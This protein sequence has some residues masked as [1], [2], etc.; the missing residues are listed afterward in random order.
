MCREVSGPTEKVS[1]LPTWWSFLKLLHRS[2]P[3]HRK[4]IARRE[5]LKNVYIFINTKMNFIYI[6]LITLEKNLLPRG[7]GIGGGADEINF[8]IYVCVYMCNCCAAPKGM[9]STAGASFL[10][11]T[12]CT[13]DSM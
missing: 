4:A 2:A 9:K 6:E 1:N 11:T 5:S 7:F 13:V 3:L 10:L 8:C 12:F